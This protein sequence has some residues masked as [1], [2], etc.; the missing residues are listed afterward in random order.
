MVGHALRL[1]PEIALGSAFALG[2]AFAPGSALAAAQMTA[3]A[4][5]D[6]APVAGLRAFTA[7][8]TADWRA[9]NIGTSDL[10][11]EPG[12]A[13]D[14]YV[15]TWR[16]TARGIFR[17]LYSNDVIQKSW[18]SVKDGHVRPEKYHAEQG[19]SS[20]NLDF[21]WDLRRVRGLSEKKPVDLELGAG[22][23]DVMS[24]QIEVLL[25]VRNGSLP[26]TFRILD[27]DEFKDFIYTLEGPVRLRTVLGELDTIVV[28]SHRTGNSR[29]L[30]MWF[31][32]SLGYVPVQAERSRDGKLEFAMRIKSLSP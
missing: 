25:D 20:V 32:P 17:L 7:H 5:A 9:I 31:A 4:D 18:F 19:D 13:A 29:V 26:K 2:W 1:A 8:Y 27:R 21:D 30:R 3:E 6:P 12:A 15:Y 11:L 24:I 22:A 23:Q 14:T 16:V 10:E 28:A